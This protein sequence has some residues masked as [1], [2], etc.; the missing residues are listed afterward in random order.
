MEDTIQ[1]VLGEAWGILICNRWLGIQD[2][3]IPQISKN[4]LCYGCYLSNVNNLDFQNIYP[5]V[6]ICL[7]LS[8]TQDYLVVSRQNLNN[9]YIKNPVNSRPNNFMF[10]T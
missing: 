6:S 8:K 7:M 10:T 2:L 9:S 4:T 1:L 3:M 5:L